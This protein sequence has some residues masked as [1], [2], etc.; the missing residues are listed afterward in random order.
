MKV[1]WGD[2]PR[3][4]DKDG[5]SIPITGTWCSEC[6]YPT[7]PD[8]GDIHPMCDSA[9]A[10]PTPGPRLISTYNGRRNPDAHLQESPLFAD[11]R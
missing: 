1:P 3:V 9:G 5:H 2:L 10:V 6:G 8:H 11:A 4:T 7:H